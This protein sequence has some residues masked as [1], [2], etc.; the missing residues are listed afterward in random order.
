MIRAALCFGIGFAGSAGGAAAAPFDYATAI[1]QSPRP[2]EVVYTLDRATLRVDLS[3]PFTFEGDEESGLDGFSLDG[4]LDAGSRSGLLTLSTPTDGPREAY[5]VRISENFGQDFFTEEIDALVGDSVWGVD[6]PYFRLDLRPVGG[7]DL[8]AL[9]P[10]GFSISTP[11]RR[12]PVRCQPRDGPDSIVFPTSDPDF[13]TGYLSR[14]APV[15]LTSI[16]VPGALGLSALAL[17]SLGWAGCRR[18]A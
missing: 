1:F 17:I 10:N 16:P 5:E 2:L 9:F 13:P 11:C 14:G 3:F 6:Y 8:D 18:R 15:E 4:V 12:D 7:R